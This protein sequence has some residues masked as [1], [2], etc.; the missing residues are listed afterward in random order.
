MK[1]EH[2]LRFIIVSVFVLLSG[3]ISITSLLRADTSH[4]LTV[5][6]VYRLALSTQMILYFIILLSILLRAVNE[7]LD[8][9]L[10]IVITLYTM[11]SIYVAKLFSKGAYT[12]LIDWNLTIIPSMRSSAAYIMLSNEGKINFQLDPHYLY[13]LEYLAV[14]IVSCITGLPYHLSYILSAGFS[15]LILNSIII[16]MLLRNIKPCKQQKLNATLLLISLAILFN[17]LSAF[18]LAEFAYARSLFYLVIY[19]TCLKPITD[20][21]KTLEQSLL[22]I[23]LA[24]GAI[25]G[26]LRVSLILAI[27]FLTLTITYLVEETRL[28]SKLILR[29]YIAIALFS[30]AYMFF[31]SSQYVTGYTNYLEALVVSLWSLIKHGIFEVER[32][33][34]HTVIRARYHSLYHAMSILGGVSLLLTL[35]ISYL[36]VF[37]VFILGL[38]D[39]NKKKL[40][41]TINNTNVGLALYRNVFSITSLLCG[42][43]LGIAYLLNI[44][45]LFTIDF[46]SMTDLLL[47]LPLAIISHIHFL[48]NKNKNGRDS[49]NKEATIKQDVAL[50]LVKNMFAVF[51]VII[52]TFSIFG[53]ALRHPILCMAEAVLTPNNSLIG[54]Q[55]ADRLFVFLLAYGD[56]KHINVELHTIFSRLYLTLPLRYYEVNTVSVM[57]SKFDDM[58]TVSSNTIFNNI[59]YIL[60][61]NTNTL[62]VIDEV[63]VLPL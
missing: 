3:L 16:Y 31:Y 10:I 8:R 55:H 60:I 47:L 29:V 21:L 12:A 5:S 49:Q 44:L 63:Q 42:G 53:L 48:E 45:G 51:I 18:Y 17:L 22:G 57:L 20:R 28:R 43:I 13:P 15:I 62:T 59:I 4:A 61:E 52:S 2:R 32:P 1:C 46:E 34:L 23:L 38:I 41:K 56:A 33:P 25:I 6:M 40:Y 7:S 54:L 30:I 26:S 19:I 24:M 35:I 39:W 27:L 14:H 58:H 37:T 36:M 50:K 9:S 11:F